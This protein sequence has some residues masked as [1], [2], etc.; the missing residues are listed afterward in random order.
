MS[1]HDF[2]MVMTPQNRWGRGW[3]QHRQGHQL[4]WGR[5]WGQHQSTCRGQCWGQW[6]S[7]RRGQRGRRWRSIP[8]RK[9]PQQTDETLARFEMQRRGLSWL[10]WV[11]LS[12]DKE[13]MVLLALTENTDRVKYL[14][15]VSVSTSAHWNNI[16]ATAQGQRWS[17]FR[18]NSQKKSW[19]DEGPMH[20]TYMIVS[21]IH[22]EHHHPPRFSFSFPS[23]A[24]SVSY[25]PNRFDDNGPP[26]PA[27]STTGA[28][29][30]VPRQVKAHRE[31]K[32][33]GGWWGDNEVE[34][35]SLLSPLHQLDADSSALHKTERG[36]LTSA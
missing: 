22:S 18:R 32:G 26:L 2:N 9:L 33:C 28:L 12:E 19:T 23:S 7:R 10:S 17:Q 25:P 29:A 8:T 3:R 15:L 20:E 16:L 34:K 11:Y 14:R 13:E 6:G 24:S 30:T 31:A 36:W 27:P 21:L 1:L 4:H 35:R 5:H